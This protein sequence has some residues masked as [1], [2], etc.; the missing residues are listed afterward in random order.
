MV[1][2]KK[3][4]TLVIKGCVDKVF[5]EMWFGGNTK[6]WWLNIFEKRCGRREKGD[7]WVTI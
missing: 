7:T 1:S 4:D 2:I 5:K 6:T 3:E